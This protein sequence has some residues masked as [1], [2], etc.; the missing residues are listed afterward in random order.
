MKN[1]LGNT[2]EILNFRKY[3]Y[4]MLDSIPDEKSK[5]F[6]INPG[7]TVVLE[8]LTQILRIMAEASLQLVKNYKTK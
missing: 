4:R 8:N 7:I 5:M 6:E 2:P 3:L 1:I